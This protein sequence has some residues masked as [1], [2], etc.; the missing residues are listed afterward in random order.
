MERIRLRSVNWEH[1]MLLTPEHFLRQERYFESLFHWN[2]AYLTRGSGL[3]GGGIRSNASDLGAVRHDPVIALEENVETLSISVSQC[4][5]ISPSGL[6]VDIDAASSISERFPRGSLAGVAE[7]L[8]YVVC[9]AANRR[10]ADDVADEFN[11]QMKTERAFS[12]RIALDVTAA[13]RQDAIVIARLTTPAVGLH[14]EKDADYIP[15]C[16]SLSAHSELTAGWRRIVD[17]VTVLTSGY[18]ELHRA[19]REFLVLFT[20][21]GIETEL[22]RD[23][24]DFAERMVLALQETAYSVL[25]RTQPPAQFFGEIRKLLHKAATFFDLAAGMQQYYETLR[26]TGETELVALIELQRQMLQTGRSMRLADDL[27]VEV[28]TAL[29]ALSVLAKLER[30][31]E[32]KYIDFRRSPSLEGMNFIFDRGGKVLY[33]LAAKPSRVQG[34][35]DELSIFFSQ[36]RLEGRDRYR[37]ILVGNRDAPY[38]K[39][40]SI[41]AEIRLNEGSGFRREAII[42]TTEAKLDDQYNFEFDFEAPDVPTITDLRVTVQA[43]H[44]VRTALLF[45]RHRFY[46]GRTG[47]TPPASPSRSGPSPSSF[48]SVHGVPMDHEA[49]PDS[50]SSSAYANHS[51]STAILSFSA[52]CP[53]SAQGSNE[54]LPPWSPRPRETWINGGNGDDVA[55][56]RRRRLE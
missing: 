1:G 27:G 21:R 43:F 47:E 17:A 2:A 31:L 20:E 6:I 13:E 23:A 44:S 45:S 29:Q 50:D 35:V 39:G 4:R 14:F 25:D 7:A 48:S 56:P 26:E 24:I 28:R 9:D 11:P 10:K 8:V 41:S 34:I 46:A 12:Y 5:G 38:L 30:A 54:V 53:T 36:L 33:K 18:A 19:M 32:G 49:S 42:L 15:A 37:L 22:D 40:T 16:V 52:A 51:D 3:V 55:R